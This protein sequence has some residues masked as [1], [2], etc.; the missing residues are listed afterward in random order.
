MTETIAFFPRSADFFSPSLGKFW[1]IL[2]LA[3][4]WIPPFLHSALSFLS[5]YFFRGIILHFQST[6]QGDFRQEVCRP[7]TREYAQTGDPHS[8]GCVL[9]RGSFQPCGADGGCTPIPFHS[10]YP[11][12]SRTL[13]AP[14]PS[15]TA[16]YSYL[17][18]TLAY[19]TS[20]FSLEQIPIRL[21][22]VQERVV[23]T[24]W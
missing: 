20:P 11:H 15:K 19:R 7:R 23:R 24:V 21:P 1:E 8:L 17:Y 16:K 14:S 22:C 3:Q 12:Y 18:S 4:G 5:R 9:W 6:E 10:V 13:P 2:L